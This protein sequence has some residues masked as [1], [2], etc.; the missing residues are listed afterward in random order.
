[1][2]YYFLTA[3]K[4]ASVYLQQ[5]NQNTGLDEILE[6]D[7]E[8]YKSFEMKGLALSNLRL[9]STLAMQPQQNVSPH[10]PSNFNKLSMLEFYKALE[11]NP[12]SVLALNFNHKHL[13]RKAVLAFAGEI[14]VF[15][16]ML[17]Y[18]TRGTFQFSFAPQ[19]PKQ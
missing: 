16:D 4:D 11:I 19:K 8:D 10:N 13:L 1:M 17:L 18:P 14:W 7:P 9:E 12:N 2:A 5:P 3:S 6:I 15:T